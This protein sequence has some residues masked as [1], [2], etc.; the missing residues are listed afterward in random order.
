MPIGLTC[1]KGSKCYVI[2]QKNNAAR[3]KSC[4]IYYL[5]I[6]F[7]YKLGDIFKPT[8]QSLADFIECFCFYILI[9][10]EPA[11]SFTVNS[12]FFSQVICGDIFLM[13]RFPESIK[14]NH[15]NHSLTRFIMGVIISIIKGIYSP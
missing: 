6:L 5:F 7:R 12:A 10:F 3:N 1:Q 9:S 11:D 4:G 8:I 2:Q 14:F 15:Y 13:H